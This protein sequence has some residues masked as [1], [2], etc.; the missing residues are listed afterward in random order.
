M[1]PQI[2]GREGSSGWP[3]QGSRGE[4]DFLR[5]ILLVVQ[6]YGDRPI[7]QLA[8]PHS[9]VSIDRGAT[10]RGHVLVDRDDVVVEENLALQI[11]DP[12]DTLDGT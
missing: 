3:P 5:C 6:S 9:E 4:T 2:S 7:R 8:C 11:A 1:L 12:R 10:L